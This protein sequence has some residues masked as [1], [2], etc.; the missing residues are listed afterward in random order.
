MT[1]RPAGIGFDFDHTLGVDNGLERRALYDV[2]A[3]VGRPISE[4]DENL[5]AR[6]DDL[7]AGFRG[8]AFDIEE[9]LHR[10]SAER[11]MPDIAPEHW[12]ER[13]YALVD[14]LVRPMPGARETIALLRARGVPLAILTNGWSPLQQMKIARALGAHAIDIVLVSDEIRSEKPER[15]AFDALVDAL[16]GAREAT[17]YVGD[18]ARTDVGGA[19]AA[20]LRAIWFDWEGQTYPPDLPPPS[21][22]VHALRELEALTENASVP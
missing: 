15:A 4:R 8:G 7:L 13:C 5:R 11:G 17:W 12:R 9:M 1:S 6:V 16:G 2:A 20:G 14:E 22:I 21:G 3:V 18:N 10:F 19:L